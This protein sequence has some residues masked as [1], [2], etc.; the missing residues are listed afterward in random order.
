MEPQVPGYRAQRPRH[1]GSARAIHGH[2][3]RLCSRLYGGRE[4]QLISNLLS[5]KH[6]LDFAV[7]D[8]TL[9]VNGLQ[10]VLQFAQM[11]RLKKRALLKSTTCLDAV[12]CFAAHQGSSE[13]R[14]SRRL[15]V[16]VRLFRRYAPIEKAQMDANPIPGRYIVDYI[17]NHGKTD[18]LDKSARIDKDFAPNLG[19]F[20]SG[21]FQIS[22]RLLWW[23]LRKVS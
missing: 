18:R 9:N 13:V 1:N 15:H 5:F 3:C 12:C 6:S 17:S 4:Q 7:V 22:R 21:L 2:R 10:E 8:V 23:H 11:V 19:Q 14:R 20:L 16:S